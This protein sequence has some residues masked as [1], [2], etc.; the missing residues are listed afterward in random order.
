MGGGGGG[1]EGRGV[2]LNMYPMPDQNNITLLLQVCL[3]IPC[4]VYRKF[5]V[6]AG[7]RVQCTTHAFHKA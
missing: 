6:C 4:C 5:M 2:L 3:N 7:H 1:R